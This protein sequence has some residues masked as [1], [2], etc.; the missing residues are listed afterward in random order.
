L[1]EPLGVSAGPGVER[2][3]RPAF[4]LRK[5][6]ERDHQRPGHSAASGLG[7]HEQLDHVRPMPLVR[8]CGQGELHGSHDARTQARHEHAPR[9]GTHPRQHLVHP[10]CARLVERERDDE[11]DAGAVVHDGAQDL[12]EHGDVALESR[13]RAFGAPLLD[14]QVIHRKMVSRAGARLDATTGNP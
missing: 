2:E 1:I 7:M 9:T 10:E 11:A 13:A 12:A 6:L 8:R 3:Q 5:R 4:G 14:L